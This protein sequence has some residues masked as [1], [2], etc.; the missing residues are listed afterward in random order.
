MMND[1]SYHRRFRVKPA[2]VN[3]AVLSTVECVFNDR[4]DGWW[5][6]TWVTAEMT[7]SP[8]VLIALDCEVCFSIDLFGSYD[9]VPQ[10]IYSP[11]TQDRPAHPLATRFY[12]LLLKTY[13]HMTVV[14]WNF[15]LH[16][17]ICR[18]MLL[19]EVN[20]DKMA[21]LSPTYKCDK[22]VL[23]KVMMSEHLLRTPAALIHWR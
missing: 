7:A 8:Q 3:N 6:H 20:Q 4:D 19:C 21:C 5:T 11:Q 10:L 15:I 9:R 12:E 13:Y 16:L 17:A 22:A 14:S 23:Y 18:M 2:S 1:S